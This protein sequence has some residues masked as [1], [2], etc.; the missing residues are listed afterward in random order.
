MISGQNSAPTG[1]IS[2]LI[3]KAGAKVAAAIQN[4]SHKT[5][6]DFSYLLQQAQI[7]SSFRT[8]VKACSSSATGLYQFIDST[9]LSMVN[10]YGD[11]YGLSDLADQINDNGKVASNTVKKQILELRKNPEL[12]SLMAAEMASDNKDYLEQC[13]GQTAGAT[14]LYMAHFMGP[15]GA[16]KFLK[17][18]AKNPDANAAAMFPT[19]AAANKGVFYDKSGKAKSL[20]QVYAQFDKKFSILDSDNSCTSTASTTSTLSTETSTA[21]VLAALTPRVSATPAAPLYSKTSSLFTTSGKDTASG[22]SSNFPTLRSIISPVDVLE[23]LKTQDDK[24]YN[25]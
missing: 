1:T 12:C 6:V 9:W 8:D 16:G 3:E 10:K 25:S 24:H 17:A 5:G 21:N 2:G 11:K 14:E 22:I 13:T 18:M 4:A 20:E 7:E 23:L 19:A 15:A